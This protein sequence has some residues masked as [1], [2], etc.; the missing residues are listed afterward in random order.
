M[1]AKIESWVSGVPAAGRFTSIRTVKPTFGSALA[2]TDGGTTAVP[3]DSAA[4]T[5]CVGASAAAALL[6]DLA[7]FAG[8]RV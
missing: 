1:L 5:V 6:F 4:G 8:Q 7:F 2:T 3:C